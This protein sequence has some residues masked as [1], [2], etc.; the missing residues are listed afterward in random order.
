[1]LREFI[2]HGGCKL[3][4]MRKRFISILILLVLYSLIP[5]QDINNTKVKYKSFDNLNSKSENVISEPNKGMLT[6]TEIS[7]F[8]NPSINEIYLRT[9]GAQGQVKVNIYNAIG[10]LVK[11]S[12][13]SKFEHDYFIDVSDLRNG[14]YF[15]SIKD[16][17]NYFRTQKLVIE[18]S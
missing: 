5:A 12:R 15:L 13:I 11:L 8:P 9:N 10:K 16:S 4:L 17:K 18:R 1:M 2:I 14:V 3:L 6:V 7:V